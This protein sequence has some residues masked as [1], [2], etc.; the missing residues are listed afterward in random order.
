MLPSTSPARHRVASFYALIVGLALGTTT[1]GL[2]QQTDALDEAFLAAAKQRLTTQLQTDP[3]AA[4]AHYL[5][6]ETLLKQGDTTGAYRSFAMA[7]QMLP[8]GPNRPNAEAQIKELE[9]F[10]PESD[11][12]V[13]DITQMTAAVTN[14]PNPA[15]PQVAMTPTYIAPAP[16][17]SPDASPAPTPAPT[18]ASPELQVELEMARAYI[19]VRQFDEA[20]K[21]LLKIIGN[22]PDQIDALFL[23][24][25]LHF[26]NGNFPAAMAY[27]QLAGKAPGDPALQQEALKKA[28]EATE[29]LGIGG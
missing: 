28:N 16:T 29:R 17:T 1:P 6:A 5:L 12:K 2:A 14:I 4:N 24:G 20:Q 8:D 15:P 22:N 13:P 27:Y 26:S 19:T 23:L 18:T 10:V 11:R 25:E 3:R 7:L 21:V 9:S